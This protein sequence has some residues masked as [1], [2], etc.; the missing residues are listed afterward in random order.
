MEIWKQH[1][2]PLTALALC[3]VL[4]TLPRFDRQD[5]GVRAMTGD[6]RAAEGQV[7]DAAY[8]VAFVE[9]YRGAEHLSAALGPP[10]TYRPLVPFIASLLPAAPMT[11]INL[12]NEAFLLLALFALYGILADLKLERRL[13]LLG[14]ALFVFSFP[15]FYYGAIGYV[16]PVLIGLLTVGTLAVLKERWALLAVVL[17]AGIAAKETILLLLPVA[18]AAMH[19]RGGR[20]EHKLALLG[21]TV[22]A[23]AMIGALRSTAPFGGSYIWLPSAERLFDNLSRPRAWLSFALTFGIPGV[24]SLYVIR[25]RGADWFAAHRPAIRTL[26]VGLLLSFGLFAF[27]LL[28]AYADGRFIW[29]SYPFTIPLAMLAA[30]GWLQRRRATATATA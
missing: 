13:R 15:T 20:R 26:G 19:F 11:A 8:Y 21:I 30:Q 10:F 12:V 5:I 17:L 1:I 27:S 23:I 25:F 2:L 28:S 9:Y 29:P 18:A 14:C 24:L 22:L 4:V 16:D 6:A 7:S 3:L